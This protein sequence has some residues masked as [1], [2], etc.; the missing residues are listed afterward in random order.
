MR[1][2]RCQR[3]WVLDTGAVEHLAER[4][5]RLRPTA[6]LLVYDLNNDNLLRRFELPAAQTK[7]D[8]FFANIA[9]EVRGSADASSSSFDCADAHAYLADLGA[10]GVVVYSW[11]A[12]ES[13]RV[14]NHY[15]SPAPLAGAFDVA[16][17]QFQWD[18]GVFG[19][20]LSQGDDS[21]ESQRRLY[22]HAL[23]STDE[24]SVSTSWLRN[25]TTATDAQAALAGKAYSH[26]GTRGERGQA[27]ATFWWQGV[28]FYTQPNRNAL[29]CWRP[30]ASSAADARLQPAELG[31][32]LQS[33]ETMVFPNDVKV[34]A[35]GELW[36]LTD[37]LQEFA[38]GEL[39]AD[40]VNYRVLRGQT[41]EA[42]RGTVCEA[43]AA[44]VAAASSSVQATTE[45]VHAGHVHEHHAGHGAEEDDVQ[46]TRARPPKQQQQGGR[47]GAPFVGSSALMV[48][49]AAVVAAAVACRR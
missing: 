13:W 39:R 32:V 16:G 7:E 42:I 25:R 30:R 21:D 15:F 3:L 41:S 10:P 46:R 4:P 5:Q 17:R 2:D 11:R 35:A 28:L 40:R 22:F 9:V 43:T 18:D 27:G 36:V 48:G 20:A 47:G 26:H 19:V 6:Q 23:S 44:D 24:F 14:H 1:A 49:V 12:D 29:T 37:N 38:Y 33:D 34:D 45:H 31:V 8:S